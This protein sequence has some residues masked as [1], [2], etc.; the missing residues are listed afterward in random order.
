MRI[1]PLQYK[2]LLQNLESIRIIRPEFHN[3]IY[4]YV[5]KIILFNIQR[6]E[7]PNGK[8]SAIPAKIAVENRRPI[9]KRIGRVS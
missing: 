2:T 7:Y 6:A 8:Q 1:G 5:G 3:V 9:R 4:K